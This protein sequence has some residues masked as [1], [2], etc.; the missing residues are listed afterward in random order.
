MADDIEFGNDPQAIVNDRMEKYG[1]PYDNFNRIASLINARFD[2]KFTGYEVGTILRFVKEAREA[3]RPDQSNR[4][5]IK[6]Y[7][8]CQELWMERHKELGAPTFRANF[9]YSGSPI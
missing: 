5:D 4:N 6:G 3:H 1:H 9:N 8:I 2:T 7:T